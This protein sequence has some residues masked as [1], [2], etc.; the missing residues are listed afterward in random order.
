MNYARLPKIELH[1]H[2]EGAAYRRTFD[3]L[4]AKNG[5][6]VV[7]PLSQP[8]AATPGSVYFFD[9]FVHRRRLVAT[10]D[11]VRQIARDV[12]LGARAEAIVHLELRTTAAFFCEHSGLPPLAVLDA[13]IDESRRTAGDMS[14][15][16]IFLLRRDI[17]PDDNQGL[18]ELLSSS[19]FD[20]F[21]AIDIAGNEVGFPLAP[22]KNIFNCVRS[23]G[24]KL[25]LHAGEWVGPD[26]VRDALG[27]QPDRIGH[28]IRIIDDPELLSVARELGSHF[29]VCPLSNRRTLA[30]SENAA[31]PI[32]AMLDAGLKVSVSADDPGIFDSVTADD[33]ALLDSLYPTRD[34][35]FAAAK[36]TQLFAIDAAFGISDSRRSE[37][38]TLINSTWRMDSV[39]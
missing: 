19:L 10:L 28:G 31:H 32:K 30:V 21:S 13:I 5:I 24:K 16:F 27:I 11:D 6:D 18:R 2:L 34:A 25:T 39:D 3:A 8:V 26:A 7:E 9:C 33:L 35:G 12:I 14:L 4:A 1:R 38:R 17:P 29:E 20:Q 15:A 22:F 37:L 23:L 36:Q